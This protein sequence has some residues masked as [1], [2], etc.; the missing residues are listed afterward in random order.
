MDACTTRGCFSDKFSWLS[1]S[2]VGTAVQQEAV[3]GGGRP[4]SHLLLGSAEDISLQCHFANICL[5]SK[6]AV[7]VNCWPAKRYSHMSLTNG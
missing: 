1:K 7:E 6:D 3:R 4:R 5:Y 2:L